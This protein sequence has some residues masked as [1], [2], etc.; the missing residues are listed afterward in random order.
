MLV[1]ICGAISLR[2]ETYPTVDVGQQDEVKRVTFGQYF[3]SPAAWALSIRLK[4]DSTRILP[5]PSPCAMVASQ[6][7]S[8]LHPRLTSDTYVMN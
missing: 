8:K 6:T 4:T 7:R 5:T 3:G 2:F 1:D